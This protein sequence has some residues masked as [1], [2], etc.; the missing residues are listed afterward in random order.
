MNFRCTKYQMVDS[1]YGLARATLRIGPIL[2]APRAARPCCP[3]TPLTTWRRLGAVI[4]VHLFVV[5][6][7]GWVQSEQHEIIQYL[8]E[9]NRVLKEQLRTSRIRFTDDQR[10]RL[11]GLG[12]PLGR[13]LLTQIAL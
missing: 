10:R 3:K 8:Q 9:E 11:A 1:R 4:P 12:A 7:L 5:S 13:R 2:S 6:F